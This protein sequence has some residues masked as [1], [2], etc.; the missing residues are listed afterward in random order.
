MEQTP[1]SEDALEPIADAGERTSAELKYDAQATT[2]LTEYLRVYTP[3][4]DAGAID[5]LNK[6]YRID[7]ATPLPEF[8]SQTAKAYAAS[9]L[10]EPTRRLFA[11]VCQPGTTQRHRAIQALKGVHHKHIVSL[12]AAGAVELSRPA[13]QR[14][15]IFFERP[16]GKKLAALLAQQH[17]HLNQQF[18]IE[19]IIAPIAS[20]IHQFEE[21]D[22]SHGLINLDNI[23]F[24]DT[25]MV[26]PCVAEP[27][28]Y[29]QI[30][31]YEPAERMQ[32]LATGKGEGS[33]S[34]DF[35]AL[36]VLVLRII[37]GAQHFANLNPDILT[38]LILREGVYWALMRNAEVPEIF[39]DF[40]RGIFS[41]NPEDRWDY[42]YV[43]PWL[44][45]KRYNVLP[46]PQP[47]EAIRPFEFADTQAYTRRELA[48]VLYSDWDKITEPV[49]SGKITQWVTVS[50]RNKEIAEA[51][52]RISRTVNEIG[53]RN[54][55]QLSEQLMRLLIAL[56]PH[57]PIRLNQLSFH[58]DGLDSLVA[59][60]YN[61]KSHQE[62]QRIA[63]FIEFNM[64]TFWLDQ[65]RKLHDYSV[66]TVI[67][68]M[69]IKLD[70]LRSTLRNPGL[71]FG[72]ERMLYDLNPDMPCLS[73]LFNN[74]H[75]T[76]LP[77]L[78][79]RLDRLAPS[80]YKN[81]D[82]IDRHIAA[83]I[84]SKLAIQHEIHL[85]D[86]GAVPALAGHRAIMALHLLSLAQHKVDNIQ[87][88]GLTHWLALRILPALDIIHS[89]TLR[90]RLKYL[91]LEQAQAGYTQLM[92]DVIVNTDYA[93]ADREGFK[94]AWSMYQANAANIVTYRKGVLI[95][96]QSTRVGFMIAK[97]L[98]Y[99][100]L[101]YSFIDVITG[102]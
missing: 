60:F 16:H 21:L 45:G 91:L 79:M 11:Q 68:N 58:L 61:S 82:P 93:T 66:P 12:V 9:D 77:A 65:Q 7:L 90:Q 56:D 78:L 63:K 84:A 20:A 37:Q 102:R 36:A 22:I 53:N 97:T 31:Y 30:F 49:Q 3:S 40:F 42:H 95:D 14:F 39:Y 87:L 19:R 100:L 81:E 72:L 92:A 29:S 55:V 69:F 6:R 10:T 33:I 57:G 101:L 41:Q 76:T 52:T 15:V 80:L 51:V 17:A 88:P 67:N 59:D 35:Y 47:V 5:T 73:P 44:E 94:Q 23:Y 8:D 96:Q 4:A 24:N 46:P 34:H 43:K 98:A 86:L 89:R 28:G 85:L 18:L 71:G 50:L 1:A 83:F 13:G 74:A 64:A 75:I 70:R 54:E 62:L 25:A 32:A 99:C 2:K 26:G 27:S 48:H 38:R